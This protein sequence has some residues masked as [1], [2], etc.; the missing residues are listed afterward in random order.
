MIRVFVLYAIRLWPGNAFPG[1]TF[2][3][4]LSDAAEQGV[5]FVN[6]G[7]LFQRHTGYIS[8][9]FMLERLKLFK[10]IRTWRC[11][12]YESVVVCRHPHCVSVMCDSCAIAYIFFPVNGHHIIQAHFLAVNIQSISSKASPTAG[13]P[14]AHI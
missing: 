2:F 10:V 6:P 12:E 8:F 1:V 4:C 3:L 7:T 14:V 5:V 13:R 11:T 9:S